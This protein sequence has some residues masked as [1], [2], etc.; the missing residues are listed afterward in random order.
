V[1][2]FKEGFRSTLATAGVL[3]FPAGTGGARV[4]PSPAQVSL[5]SAAAMSGILTF[6]ALFTVF[7]P[8]WAARSIGADPWGFPHVLPGMES[9]RAL[10]YKL[11]IVRTP[12]SNPPPA[13]R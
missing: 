3:R 12:E 8:Q 5:R 13:R 9:W 1:S 2:Q 4:A 11:S 7:L 6:A 10:S